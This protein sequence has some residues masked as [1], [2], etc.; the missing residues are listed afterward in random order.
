MFSIKAAAIT[1]DNSL[2]LKAKNSNIVVFSNKGFVLTSVVPAAQ[3]PISEGQE[4]IQ[5][6]RV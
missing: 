2:I 5:T 3:I 6:R 4:A 1:A